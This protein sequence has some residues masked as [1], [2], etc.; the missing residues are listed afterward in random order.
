MLLP[1]NTLFDLLKLIIPKELEMPM[2]GSSSV[3]MFIVAV[4][5]A[6]KTLRKSKAIIIVEDFAN[7]K[8]MIMET[9]N[10]DS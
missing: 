4:F 5:I 7:I 9:G 6:A 10:L 3:K 8:V 1:A 2:V